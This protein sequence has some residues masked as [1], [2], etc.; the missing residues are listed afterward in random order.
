MF[1]TLIEKL[2]HLFNHEVVDLEK[3]FQIS[4]TEKWEHKWESFGT[5]LLK[6]SIQIIKQRLSSKI[7]LNECMKNW[8]ITRCAS[9]GWLKLSICCA[10]TT[11]DSVDSDTPPHRRCPCRVEMTYGEIFTKCMM[12]RI[13]KKFCEKVGGVLV[14][15]DKRN[16]VITQREHAM[17][18]WNTD[19]LRLFHISKGSR[20]TISN[21]GDGSWI[22]Y[23]MRNGKLAMKQVFQKY[24]RKQ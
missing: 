23:F 7:I 17:K 3:T 8:R 6:I 21:I 16:H 20:T 1:S 4:I 14:S 10:G 22:I 9:C 13:I 11:V 18:K 12:L 2:Q 19:A 5:S 24:Q 15:W